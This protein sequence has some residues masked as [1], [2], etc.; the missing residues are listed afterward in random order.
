MK[1]V[2]LLLLISLP[3]LSFSQS[4][5]KASNF[6]VTEEG[7]VN[8]Q[9]IYENESITF[10]DLVNTVKGN[11]VFSDIQITDNKITFLGDGIKTDPKS[12]NFS[13][14]STSFYALG[15]IQAYFTI[16]YKNGRYRITA[17]NI[18]SKSPVLHLV[19]RSFAQDPNVWQY[20]PIEESV[21]SGT[22]LKKGFVKKESIIMNHAIE[23]EFQ[24]K[25]TLNDNW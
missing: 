1:K 13:A 11:R 20:S 25:Q 24:I 6:Y 16:D 23:K 4:Q 9:K 3:F 22:G 10:D 5:L 14:M 12:S 19:D 21:G 7:R 17:E 18:F 15:D 2:L 8:W